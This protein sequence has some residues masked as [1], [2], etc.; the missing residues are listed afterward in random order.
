MYERNITIKPCAVGWG[1]YG[2]Q[3]YWY[4]G[5]IE[6]LYRTANTLEECIKFCE[7]NKMEYTII[8]ELTNLEKQMHE[9]KSR[10][11]G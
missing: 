2:D 3:Y 7:D 11:G 8:D 10:Y 5:L 1:I 6:P 9:H 4:G